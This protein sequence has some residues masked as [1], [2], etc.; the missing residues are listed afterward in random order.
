MVSR[1]YL[2]R[3]PKHVAHVFFLKLKC[4][5]NNSQPRHVRIALGKYSSYAVR[6]F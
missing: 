6:Y 1:L 4:T 2:L 3:M 5:L